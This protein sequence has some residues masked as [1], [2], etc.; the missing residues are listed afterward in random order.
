MP[1]VTV[2]DRVLS[3]DVNPRSYHET[4]PAVLFIHGSGRDF[5]DWQGQL[6]GL[7][8]T[9]TAVA[10]DLPGHGG[11]A[12]P[13]ESS[14]D[15]YG[16][17]IAD[18]I[19]ALRLRKVVV[20]GSS[21]GSAIALWLGINPRPWLAGIGI[22]GGGARLRV[23][24]DFLEGLKVDHAKAA[25]GLTD[26]ALSRKTVGSLRAEVQEKFLK[27]PAEITYG[28]LGA[29]DRFDVMDKLGNITV[30]AWLCVGEDDRLTPVK[31]S[32]FL[33]DRIADSHMDV[34]P[35]AGHM[36]FLEQVERFNGLLAQFLA[37]VEAATHSPGE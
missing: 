11:S 35:D 29:C 2:R 31:Y 26:F 9:V 30:P 18:F 27:C 19:E 4:A 14:V 20:V 6:S 36:V 33:K 1:K 12:P 10:V 15:A 32:A 8:K 5:E 34:V 25:A 7:S 21:L 3:Y 22:V 17:W 28:D 23:H 13:G 24:P 16:R 37:R